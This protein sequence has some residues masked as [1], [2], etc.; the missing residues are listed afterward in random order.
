MKQVIVSR[1]AAAVEF[2][3]QEAGLEETVPVIEQAT[4][5]DV[6]GAVVYGN[7]PL[8]LAALAHTVIAVEFEGAPPRGTEYTVVDMHAAGARLRAYKVQSAPKSCYE[9][10]PWCEEETAQLCSFPAP[11]S[12]DPQSGWVVRRAWPPSDCMSGWLITQPP[13]M[14][15]CGHCGERFSETE[16]S[17]IS[18]SHADCP[19]CG[20]DN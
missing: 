9:D 14:I 11:G 8:H 16:K 13:S 1:H 3:R 4:A 7:L 20:R 15:T 18:G 5:E 17:N 2:I 6:R 10:M 19:Y 12:V